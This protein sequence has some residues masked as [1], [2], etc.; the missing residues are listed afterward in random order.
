[1]GTQCPLGP[2]GLGFPS[3][4]APSPSTH[5]VHGPRLSNS[6]LRLVR[7][8][9]S[10]SR[11]SRAASQTAKPLCF[12][13]DLGH[14]CPGRHEGKGPTLNL[15]HSASRSSARPPTLLSEGAFCAYSGQR[16]QPNQQ[17]GA[18]HKTGG[19]GEARAPEAVLAHGPQLRA[20][21][22]AHVERLRATGGPHSARVTARKKKKHALARAPLRALVRRAHPN[23]RLAPPPPAGRRHASR[24]TFSVPKPPRGR[25]GP[26]AAARPPP[27]A[28]VW[29]GP[30]APDP[31]PCCIPALTRALTRRRHRRRCLRSTLRPRFTARG[32]SSAAAAPRP[33]GFSPHSSLGAILHSTLTANGSRMPLSR[34][35][36]RRIPR[37]L[38]LRLKGNA[39]DLEGDCWS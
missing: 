24:G 17:Q 19:R 1:M 5:P 35:S 3:R 23:L 33:T 12:S 39:S 9:L 31:Q 25:L 4:V 13:A 30:A 29:G 15:P 18:R 8:I 32:L 20:N 37:E 38:P 21:G 26:A 36:K 6:I 11:R 28:V 16:E 22:N 34:E 14:R 2:I 27:P 10:A 7:A